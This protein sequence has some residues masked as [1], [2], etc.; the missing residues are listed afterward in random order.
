MWLNKDIRNVIFVRFG[1]KKSL[2]PF[3]VHRL[4]FIETTRSPFPSF[5]LHLPSSFFFFFFSSFFAIIF[6]VAQQK[7]NSR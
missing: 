5:Q 6:L 1:L 2:V 7:K 4:I 3:S